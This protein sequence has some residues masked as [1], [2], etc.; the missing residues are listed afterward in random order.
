MEGG[1]KEDGRRI[2]GGWKEEGGMI[3]CMAGKGKRCRFGW[4]FAFFACQHTV[5]TEVVIR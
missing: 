2:E 5:L 4:V 1:W 3:V